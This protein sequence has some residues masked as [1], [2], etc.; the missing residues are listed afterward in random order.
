M[1]IRPIQEGDR[2]YFI[3]SNHAFYHSPGGVP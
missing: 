1:L 3:Q 2:D